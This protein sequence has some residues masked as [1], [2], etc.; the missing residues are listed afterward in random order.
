MNTDS[1]QQKPHPKILY[2]YRDWNDEFSKRSIENLEV[3]FPSPRRF[4]D[5]FDCAIPPDPF[6]L[7]ED[8]IKAA[9]ARFVARYMPGFNS[10]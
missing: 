4:N 8:G 10:V 9:A 5:P 2:K 6:G 1:E 3:F 7:T